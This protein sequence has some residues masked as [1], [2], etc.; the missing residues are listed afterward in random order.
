[1]GSG[2]IGNGEGALQPGL[3][4]ENDFY[5]ILHLP[6]GSRPSRLKKEMARSD[7]NPAV[8]RH[9][10][11]PLWMNAYFCPLDPLAPAGLAAFPAGFA[12][13]FVPG[14]AGVVASGPAPLW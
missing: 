10:R 12:A 9:F 6:R 2:S 13:G 3:P 8:S 7:R 4:K 1:V 14:L 5:E 11:N